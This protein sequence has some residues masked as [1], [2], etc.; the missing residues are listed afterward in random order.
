MFRDASSKLP[1]RSFPSITSARSFWMIL[2]SELSSV[3]VFALS[4]SHESTMIK[5]C[6]CHFSDSAVRRPS[7]RTALQK[8]KNAGVPFIG[9]G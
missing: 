7:D 1:F 9:S 8:H 2:R 5:L 6:S 3:F 4:S